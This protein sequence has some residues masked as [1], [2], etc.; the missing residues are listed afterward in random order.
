MGICSLQF[1]FTAT[2]EKNILLYF[3]SQSM[4][5]S[6]TCNEVSYYCEVGEVDEFWPRCCVLLKCMEMFFPP[7]I[8]APWSHM[9][10]S[11]F[12]IQRGTLMGLRI[13]CNPNCMLNFCPK[14][15][16]NLGQKLRPGSSKTGSSLYNMQKKLAYVLPSHF[17]TLN[18]VH[19]SRP[20]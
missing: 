7:N 1:E 15:T 12:F 2:A 16:R 8:W 3:L 14:V 5:L 9:R 20:T 10:P 13:P 17:S 11:H 19:L 6:S 18:Y 4:L